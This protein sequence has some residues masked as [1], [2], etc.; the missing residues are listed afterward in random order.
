MRNMKIYD[1]RQ[2]HLEPVK[3]AMLSLVKTFDWIFYR[4]YV[5]FQSQFQSDN[6]LWRYLQHNNDS[7]RMDSQK[8]I[9]YR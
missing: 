8:I 3:N 7:K 9:V 2:V 6:W 4:N 1:F 5:F